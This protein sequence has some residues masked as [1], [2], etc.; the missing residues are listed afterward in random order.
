MHDSVLPEDFDAQVFL[1]DYWQKKPLLIRAGSV[2]FMDLL[3]PEELAGLAC[4]EGVES[5]LVQ[6]N[7]AQDTWTLRQGPFSEDDFLSLPESHYSLLVQA[8]DHWVDD[9]AAMLSDFAFIP[10]W[11]ID[12][13]A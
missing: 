4:E 5:R 11:R 1:R 10:S 7:A 12:V 2:S 9:V 13:H 8:V 3:E 6:V